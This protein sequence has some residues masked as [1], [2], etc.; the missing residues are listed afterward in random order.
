MQADYL[1]VHFPYATRSGTLSV[2]NVSAATQHLASIQ[3]QSGATIICELKQ[4]DERAA[5]GIGWLREAPR[6]ILF[7][8]RARALLG[9]W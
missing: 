9:C 6:V 8:C 4:G 3:R 5:A 7:V 2:S 1:P